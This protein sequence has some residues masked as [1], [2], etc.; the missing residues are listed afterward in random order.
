M[1]R[2]FRRLRQR[3]LTENR[4]SK[5]LLYAL[6]EILLVMI[7]ILLALEVNN[8]NED[9]K[10]RQTEHQLL[11]NLKEEIVRNREML[12]EA[13]SYTTKSMSGVRQVVEIYQNG[14]GGYDPVE[15]DSLL[16]ICQWAWTYDPVMGVPI[17]IRTSGQINTIRNPELRLFVAS[18]EEMVRD[19]QEEGQQ[20]RWMIV[21]QF[22]PMVGKYVSSNNRSH[23]IGEGYAIVKKSVFESDYA[24]LFADRELENL[25]TY[26][27]VW[28]ND[29]LR[30]EKEFLG[31]LDE[32]LL[33]VDN[34]LIRW[35]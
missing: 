3:V 28:R 14:P 8:W 2:Y 5:Y 17:S 6:G 20:L 25:I 27:H 18:F 9:R 7:G 34:E 21:E 23:Y 31:R 11:V 19:V 30:E 24:G 15:L 4:F 13:I 35:D 1:F 33:V 16:G 29:Q 32:I 12:V 10:M 26:I 22:N